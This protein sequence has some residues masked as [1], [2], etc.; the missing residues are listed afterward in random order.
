MKW[1]DKLLNL[2]RR[3]IYVMVLLSVIV[4]LMNPMGLPIKTSEPVRKTHEIIEKLPKDCLVLMSFDYTP[5]TRPELHPTALAMCDQMMKNG[6]KLAFI[7][8][9]PEGQAI[10]DETIRDMIAAHP[11]K[12]YGKDLVNLGY[13]AGNEAVLVRMGLDFRVQFPTDT[14]GTPL[15]DIPMLR[16]LTSL[17]QF[18]QVVSLSM[19]NPGALEHIRVTATEHK[20]PLLVAATAVMTPQY[21]PYYNSGQVQGLVGGLQGAAE[22]EAVSGFKG[23][24]TAGM[25]AQS[26]THFLIAGLIVMANILALIKFLARRKED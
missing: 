21:F 20:M 4:P 26:I 6:Q 15:S 23:K 16:D 24:A 5:S 12:E 3:I 17:K 1:V 7:S 11:D 19:G 8:L 18:T 10:I 25:D 14:R 9:W 13:K 2:D 22:Y